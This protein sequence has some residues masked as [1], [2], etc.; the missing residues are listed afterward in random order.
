MLTTHT[1]GT[2]HDLV[3][4]NEERTG[5]EVW[6]QLRIEGTPQNGARSHLAMQRI[7]NPPKCKTYEE[8]RRGILQWDNLVKEKRLRSTM[9]S[10]L[11]KRKF[12]HLCID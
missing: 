6:R 7:M 1:S 8:L 10:S 12:E 9:L 5:V 2:A 4:S 3:E 11:L